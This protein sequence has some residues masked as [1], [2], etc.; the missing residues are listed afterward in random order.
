MGVYTRRLNRF[1][2]YTL[3]DCA[4]NLCLHYAGRYKPCPLEV[5]CCAEERQQAIENERAGPQFEAVR[6]CPV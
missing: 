6:P 5:C 4:C 1:K 2:G 3:E